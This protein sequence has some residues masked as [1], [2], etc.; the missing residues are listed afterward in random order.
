M[1][2]RYLGEP[3]FVTLAGSIRRTAVDRVGVNSYG[4]LKYDGNPHYFTL[5][6]ALAAEAAL[7]RT[8][9]V[10]EEL[11]VREMRDLRA[12]AK[13]LLTDEYRAEVLGQK[14]ERGAKLFGAIPGEQY[15][16]D[17]V[18]PSGYFEPG[19]TVYGIVTPRMSYGTSPGWRPRPYFLLKTKIREVLFAP[20]HSDSLHYHYK[21]TR[22]HLDK[23]LLFSR[24]TQARVAF[25]ER[26]AEET[27]GSI[28]PE[29]IQVFTTK[30][31]TAWEDKMLEQMRQVRSSLP[32]L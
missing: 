23:K 25:T 26:F 18:F 1:S 15:E 24:L 14:L 11:T 2:K 8:H 21:D 10:S 20:A 30:Q 5:E 28:L 7:I 27:G 6:E 12:Y 32:R 9:F 19:T 4:L 29:N 13:R 31:E 3:V 22:Y 16:N 17:P